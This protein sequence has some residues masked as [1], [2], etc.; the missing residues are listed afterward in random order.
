[1]R[2]RNYADRSNCGAA[3]HAACVDLKREQ[4]LDDARCSLRMLFREIKTESGEAAFAAAVRTVPGEACDR[5][6][7]DVAADFILNATLSMS[8]GRNIKKPAAMGTPPGG[9]SS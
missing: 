7:A 8:P 5:A 9:S 3:A 6:F 1:M 2:D 4:L